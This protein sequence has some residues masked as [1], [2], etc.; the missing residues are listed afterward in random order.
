MPTLPKISVLLAT[1]NRADYLRLSLACLCRQDYKG[2]WQI[3]IADD[4]SNDHT[5]QVIGE[6]QRNPGAPEISH[7][8]HAHQLFRKALILNK[9]SR[10]ATGELLLFLDGDCLPALDLLSV[11]ASR[12]VAHAFYLG[13]VYK[14]GQGFSEKMLAAS[15]PPDAAKLLKSA[16]RYQNQGKHQA[17]KVFERYCK[18]RLYT[19][20]KVRRPK[21]W[22]ANFA[23][24]RDVFETVN[25]FDENYVGWGQEDSDLRNRLVKGAFRAVSMHTQA[26]VYHLWHPVDAHARQRPGGEKNNRIYYKR[27][28]VAVVCKNGIRKL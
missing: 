25:G 12:K 23:V 28:H 6:A 26:R 5:A 3:V 1:Y 13:G 24:N 22:G 2:P 4:G 20:L 8:R 21:I 9:A 10:L 14:L 7:C 17:R 18:S 16:A 11:Y 15:Q 27:A 19:L